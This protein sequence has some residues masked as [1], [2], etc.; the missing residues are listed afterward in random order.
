MTIPSAL[1][2]EE[3]NDHP[4]FYKNYKSV[5]HKVETLE[6]ILARN[7]LQSWIIKIILKF[8]YAKLSEEQYEVFTNEVGLHISKGN[9]LSNDI[10]IFS[11]AS[12]KQIDPKSENYFDIPPKV[13]IEVDIKADLD[14]FT[15]PMDYY[16]EKTKKML[17]F[18][19]EKVIWITSKSGIVTIAEK[20]KKHWTTEDWNKSIHIVEDCSINLGVSLRKVGI[21]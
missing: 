14:S 19:V 12:L 21:I 6:N 9:N 16:Y 13:V 10:A 3:I 7:I 8:L 4:I 18:G 20:D 17:D 5:L 15:S 1:V 2:Y 11:T